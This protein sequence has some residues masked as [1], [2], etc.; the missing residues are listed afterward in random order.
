MALAPPVL[1]DDSMMIDDSMQ[2]ISPGFGFMKSLGGN[3]RFDS[4]RG[5]KRSRGG[6]VLRPA[7]H[8]PRRIEGLDVQGYAKGVAAS[9]STPKL[10]DPDDLVLD[11]ELLTEPLLAALSERAGPEEVAELAAELLKTWQKH[12]ALNEDE[13]ESEEIGPARRSPGI[14]K[15]NMLASLLVLLHVPQSEDGQITALPK[16]LLDWLDLNHN[17]SENVIEE[18]LS[19]QKRGYYASEAFWDVIYLSLNR[20]RFGTALKLLQGAR[21]HDNAEQEFDER[22]S[23]GIEVAIQAAIRLL[24]QC[25]AVALQNWDVKGSDWTL[26]RHQVEQASEDLRSYAEEESGN[27]SLWGSAL[28]RSDVLGMSARSRRV[29]SNVPFEIYEPLQDMYT[30]LKGSSADVLK[31][32]F[33]WLE[34]SIALTVWWDGNEERIGRGSLAASRQSLSRRNQT[35]EVD[36]NPLQAYR[37]QLASSLALAVR[38][39][40]V[41]EGLDITNDLHLGLACVVLDE[42]EQAI[43]LCKS[44]SMPITTSITELATAGHWIVGSGSRG[45]IENFDKSDL[46][47]L[48]YGQPEQ[49]SSIKDKILEQYAR[50]LASKER[51]A[52][53][54]SDL[55]MEGWELAMRV[56]GR[57]EDIEK[58]QSK[59]TEL[60]ERVP[61]TSPERI[62]NVLMLCNDL[63]FGQ[64]A[65]S[66]SEVRLPTIRLKVK[67]ANEVTALRRHA[68]G[69]HSPLRRSPPLLPTRTQIRQSEE[70]HRCAYHQL[71]RTI[72]CISTYRQG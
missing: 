37:A 63:G 24:Q 61:L 10:N 43:E 22:Q 49:Q 11:T 8:V 66:I 71:A 50:L 6:D 1:E 19:H 23:E 40:D 17:P 72:V 57:L 31:S 36:L 12:G 30:Q 69:F 52:S 13:I 32:S 51:F 42:V 15:A 39:E 9:A 3:S 45:T 5:N 67:S 18:V 7:Q 38:E 44:W 62:D 34:A 58:A 46:M 59:V 48:S 56:L 68:L 65:M 41:R 55:S 54:T 29:E 20:G 27:A 14:A 60:L 2:Q 16:A 4:P 28:G 70:S 53:K 64:H 21:F 25:P 26:W 35:R 47:V 33:D